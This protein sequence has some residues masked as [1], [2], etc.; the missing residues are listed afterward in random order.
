MST[1]K[2]GGKEETSSDGMIQQVIHEVGSGSRYPTLTKTNYSNWAM[3][4]KVQLN[5]R[6]LWVAV[7]PGG[8]DL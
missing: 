4:M 7:E 2:G 6:G 3:L 5:A 1:T 8:G